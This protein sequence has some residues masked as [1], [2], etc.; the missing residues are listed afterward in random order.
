[1]EGADWR[2]RA[3]GQRVLVP[4]AAARAGPIT[5]A[6]AAEPSPALPGGRVSCL[7]TARSLPWNSADW[8]RW[9]KVNCDRRAASAPSHRQPPTVVSLSELSICQ[10]VCQSVSLSVSL[11]AVSPSDGLQSEVRR[12]RLAIQAQEHAG[13]I[14][15]G[16][17]GSR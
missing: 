16:G 6:A 3:A 17:S 5:A 12:A 15:V 8:R 4:V 14:T 7:I 2:G 13:N 11:S 1:M 10:S 9:A